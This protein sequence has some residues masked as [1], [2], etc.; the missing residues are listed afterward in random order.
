ML[1]RLISVFLPCYFFLLLAQVDECSGRLVLP[2]LGVREWKLH[3][4]AL[5]TR[6][7][8][9][10]SALSA[11][12]ISPSEAAS[13]FSA[14]VADFLGDI[15]I[16]K[17]GEG[18][19]GRGSSGSDDLSDEAFARVKAEK[20]RLQRLV[21]GR[22]R[23]L[24]QGLRAQFYQAV[25][26]LSFFKKAR[27]KRE[28]ERDTKGQE[29]SYVK[30]FWS[31]AKRAVSGTIGKEA[32]GPSFDVNF[33]NEWYKHRYSNPVSVSQEAVSWFPRLPEVVEDFDLGPVRPRDIRSVLSKK[34]PSSSPGGDGILNGHLKNLESTHHFLATLFTKTLL[35]SPNPWEGWGSSSIVLIHK[36][37]DTG[38]PAN[39][40]PIA[41]TSCV[42]KLFHQILSD[43]IGKFLVGN[44]YLDVTTQK[45][46]LNGISGCQDHNLVMGE[47]I[48]HAKA[49]GRT[50]HVTWFD[51][52]DAFGSVS[53]ELIHICMERMRL[54]ANVREYIVSLYKLLKGRVRTSDWV[55]DEF[56]FSKGVFQGDPLSPIIFLMCFNPILEDLKRFEAND[57]YVL[58]DMPFISLPFADDFNLITRDIRKHRKLMVRLNDLIRSMGLKLKPRKCR[59]LSVKA[60]KS[61]EVAF[62]LGDDE[63]LS[64]LHDRYHKFLGGYYTFQFSASSVA[65]VI[66]ERVSDQLRN[67]DSTL[68]RNEYKVRIYSEYLLGACRFVLS[69]HDLSRSQIAELESLSHSF[70]KKWL[71]LPRGASWALVHD[72]HG[73]NIKSF[74]HLYKESRSLNLSHIRLFSDSRVR[75]AL[76]SKEEREGKWRRKFSSAIY[77]KGLVEEVVPP[78]VQNPILTVGESLDDTLGSWSSLEMDEPPPPPPPPRQGGVSQNLLKSKVQAGVQE[79]VSN[80]WKEKIGSYVMQGDYIALIAEEGGSISWKSYLWDLPCGVLKFAVNAGLNTL[81]SF[82]NLKRWGKRVND[83]CPFCG[84][85]QTLAHILSN[86]Q[87]A[88]DQGRFTWRHDSVL[89]SVINLIRHNLIPGMHL[90]SDMAGLFAPSGGTIPPHVLVTQLRPDIFIFNEASREAVVFEL[91][92]P[93]DGNIDRAHAYKEGKYAPLVADL[94]RSFVT[95]HFSVEVSVR[96]QL[97][98]GNRN[99]LKAFIFRVCTD[100]KLVMKAIF[101]D[102][103]KAALLSSFSIFSARGEL[104]WNSPPPIIIR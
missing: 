29:K 1:S 26:A 74:D 10:H 94:S 89:S 52:E 55:A 47:I 93:W 73:L 75:H 50:V 27:E 16:F 9:I 48:N 12:A 36:G 11:D 98:K 34:K 63:I 97:T 85:I 76:D 61:E 4:S 49:N 42:G 8:P 14:T 13:E 31:F 25:R 2:T 5:K 59:S 88:L 6:L 53:H 18:R 15:D 87:I 72:A 43:R 64:I 82:D 60:G 66:K 68:I 91:T 102:S 78:I 104:S 67:L 100:P 3:N 33:A 17:G 46:F 54:P 99:R 41:L 86:C 21:F 58:N 84:N 65:A 38:D 90:Y 44:K 20:K 22:G 28:R 32:E 70:L 71:G 101:R 40:C 96:G 83:R 56:V 69:I 45:A 92:C 7:G 103:S 79:R 19:G 51:L 62:S 81:P 37:G 30:N 80:F 57:G 24:D 35:S 23:R 77:A 95:Y 39:F